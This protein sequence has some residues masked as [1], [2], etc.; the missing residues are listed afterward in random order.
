MSEKDYR[1]WMPVKAELHNEASRPIGYK[2]R[3]IWLCNIGENIGYENDGKGR[4]FVRP[5]LIVTAFNRQ[6]CFVVPL[7]T[8]PKRTRFHFA[9]DGNTG[10]ESVALLSQPRAIDASRLHRKIG[11]VSERDFN[12]LR[13]L[14]A[15]SLGLIQFT[16]AQGG[17]DI[18]KD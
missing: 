16:P 3:E 1:Q 9:F 5:V 8:T 11:I 15:E 17:G 13:G 7:S 2:E 6:T 18:P 14:L 4:R 12:V 10:K